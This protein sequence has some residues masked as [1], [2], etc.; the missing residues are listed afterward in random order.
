MDSLE[1][2]NV[3]IVNRTANNLEILLKNMGAKLLNFSKN[4]VPNSTITFF[5]SKTEK[6]L[7]KVQNIEVLRN[8]IAIIY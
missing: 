6:F 5:I 1:C 8:F 7:V 2:I 3:A 4:K